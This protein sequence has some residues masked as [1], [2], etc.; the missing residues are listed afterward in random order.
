MNLISRVFDKVCFQ[1]P[2]RTESDM[3]ARW[4]RNDVRQWLPNEVPHSDNMLISGHTILSINCA[5]QSDSIN[6][7][8]WSIECRTSIYMTLGVA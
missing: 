7:A 8:E 6:C 3:E 5:K 1:E 2:D 4:K